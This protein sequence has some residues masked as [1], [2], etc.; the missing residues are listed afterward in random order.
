M[1]NTA[2][3][4]VSGFFEMT[5]ALTLVKIRTKLVDVVVSVSW[6]AKSARTTAKSASAKIERRYKD[7][8][9]SNNVRLPSLSW[10]IGISSTCYPGHQMYRWSNR[11]VG[12]RGV[13]GSGSYKKGKAKPHLKV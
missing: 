5:V 10:A 6:C 4:D 9:M 3:R 8:T 11:G 7:Q 13:E 1:D 2:S 12:S